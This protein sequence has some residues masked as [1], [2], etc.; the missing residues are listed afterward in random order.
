M[1]NLILLTGSLFLTGLSFTQ[2]VNIPDFNFKNC[3]LS[4]SSINTN[5]D[6]EIQVSEAEAYTG[7]ITCL[8]QNIS[9]A[10]G[11]EAFINITI[12]RLPMNQL[13]SLNVSQNTSLVTIICPV[14]S[15]SSVDV[16]NNPVIEELILNDNDLISVEVSQNP[17][18]R[19]LEFPNNSVNALDVTQ[20]PVLEILDFSGNSVNSIDLTQNPALKSLIINGNW[21]SS[22]DL[23][24]NQAL[25]HLECMVSGIP[26][27]DF[28]QNIALQYLR[29]DF[30]P[31][32]ML[33]LSNNINL[34]TLG[35][36]GCPNLITLNLANGNNTNFGYIQANSN[37]NLICV[38]V[39]DTNYFQT[40]WAASFDS[41]AN[42][43]L[44]CQLSIEEKDFE[45]VQ[46]GP[47]P[48]SNILT[49]SNNE[50]IEK[51][52]IF[53]LQGKMIKTVNIE[54]NKKE[55]TID[56][57]ELPKGMYTVHLLSWDNSSECV[58]RI[59]KD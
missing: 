34:S 11:L 3:L 36:F 7:D 53:D 47:N 30:Y 42:F 38:Q 14:N 49:I 24:Q 54:Y 25:E 18:L 29:C 23:S 4:N 39:D 31:S 20:N 9:D 46:L 26:N 44:N 58:K 37:P 17:L 35:V 48:V 55:I 5:L 33:D 43:S 6:L 15:L 41:T 28:S 56:I 22:L 40:N 2:N 1:K 16:S 52:E 51:I 32:E 19:R 45:N 8:G 13:T 57:N 12:L 21:L 50:K 59:I 10:T 27:L